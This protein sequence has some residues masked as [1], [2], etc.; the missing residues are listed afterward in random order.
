MHGQDPH[1]ALQF[2]ETSTKLSQQTQ[3]IQGKCPM[4][5][6]KTLDNDLQ[7]WLSLVLP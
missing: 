1:S 5:E 4:L 3:L 2:K 6:H 7:V